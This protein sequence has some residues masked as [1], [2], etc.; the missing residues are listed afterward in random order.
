MT[1]DDIALAHRLADAAGAAIRPYF[2]SGLAIDAKADASP[3][4]QADRAAEAA[5]RAMLEAERPGDGIVG[6][7][8]GSVREGAER[9][10]LEGAE[11]TI[12]AS[13]GRPLATNPAATP[14]RACAGLF[15]DILLVPRHAVGTSS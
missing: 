10:V 5:M 8:Y 3:V 4:T 13:R 2:R 9:L 11:R 12:A 14:S 7:E 6:E 15:C 1:E